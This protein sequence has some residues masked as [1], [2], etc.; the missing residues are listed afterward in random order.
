VALLGSADNSGYFNVQDSCKPG[1][2]FKADLPA[3]VDITLQ[4]P[5]FDPEMLTRPSERRFVAFI[6]GINFGGYGDA[7]EAQQALYVLASFLKGEHANPK[8]NNLSA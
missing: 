3:S 4:R 5:L 2:P 7:L 6:S 1:V 8:M